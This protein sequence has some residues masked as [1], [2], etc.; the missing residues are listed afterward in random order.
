MFL[1]HLHANVQIKWSSCDRKDAKY[2]SF[3][4]RFSVGGH[5][6]RESFCNNKNFTDSETE[7]LK[8]LLH[9]MHD[10]ENTFL[11]SRKPGV[12]VCLHSPS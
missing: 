12:C 6:V 10:S 9:T 1:S 5:V 4:A 2:R 11:L 3:G 7:S 8:V